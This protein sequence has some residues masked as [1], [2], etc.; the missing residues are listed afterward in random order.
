LNRAIFTRSEPIIYAEA[1][2]EKS[3][4]RPRRICAFRRPQALNSGTALGN[5]SPNDV[6][7]RFYRL[8]FPGRFIFQA[9][10]GHSYALRHT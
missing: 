10:E 8:A 3:S 7:N 4:I 5:K 9:G 6:L 1:I 2:R